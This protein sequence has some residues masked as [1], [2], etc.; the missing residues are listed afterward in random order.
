LEFKNCGLEGKRVL[1]GAARE[2]F[3]LCCCFEGQSVCCRDTREGLLLVLKVAEYTCS[4]RYSALPLHLCILHI[5]ER[6]KRVHFIS[7]GVLGSRN[8]PGL[9]LPGLI[10]HAT[11]AENERGWGAGWILAALEKRRG[12]AGQLVCVQHEYKPAI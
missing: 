6:V 7:C 4:Q 1:L 9:L 5:R 12:K 11:T 8:R 3:L 2:V 10:G